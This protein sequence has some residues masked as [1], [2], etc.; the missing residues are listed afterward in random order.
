MPVVALPEPVL[1]NNF[2]PISLMFEHDN[3]EMALDFLVAR[4]SLDP[5]LCQQLLSEPE[6]TCIAN[7]LQVP[8]ETRIVFSTEG[9]SVIVK[10]IPPAS[11]ESTSL[12]RSRH[13]VKQFASNVFNTGE[14]EEAVS[15]TTTTEA[16]V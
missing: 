16:E 2:V 10:E 6:A 9:T 13:H 8:Q 4:A 1:N 15:T 7:G 11:N 3:F 14:E 12:Q 5:E